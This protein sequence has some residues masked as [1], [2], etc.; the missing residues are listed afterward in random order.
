MNTRRKLSS[1]KELQ[2]KTLRKATR[3]GTAWT[4]DDVSRLVT[5]IKRD[6]TSVE[7]AFALERTYYG[8]M[9]ARAHVRFAMDHIDAIVG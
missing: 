9:G 2:R 1:T 5:G 4:D 7:I 3:Q 8:V 6:E